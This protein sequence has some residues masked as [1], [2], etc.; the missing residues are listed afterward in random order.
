MIEYIGRIVGEDPYNTYTMKYK[1]FDLW[2]DASEKSYD[3][4]LATYINHSCKPNCQCLMWAVKGM[5]RLCFFATRD[6]KMEEEITFDYGWTSLE[7]SLSGG[8]G[9]K[10]QCGEKDCRGTIE[11]TINRKGK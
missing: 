11:R 3:K 6:I 2:V 7:A 9:T 4:C 5:P 10:C 1:Y 8:F